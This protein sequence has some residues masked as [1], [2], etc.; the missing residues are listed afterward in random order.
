MVPPVDCALKIAWQVTSLSP[1]VRAH[2]RVRFFRLSRPDKL[3]SG[4]LHP[5]LLLVRCLRRVFLR[6]TSLLVLRELFLPV[7]RHLRH[8]L[9]LRP[10]LHPQLLCAL[11]VSLRRLLL[12]HP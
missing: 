8:P 9:L 4:F 7:L 11:V 12:L 1:A 6:L 10:W 2:L 5:R 3:D